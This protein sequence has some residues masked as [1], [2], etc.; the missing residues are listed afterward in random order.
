M[1]IVTL[2]LPD[3]KRQTE[4]RP[5]TCPNCYGTTFQRWGKVTKPVKDQ[6]HR[7]I[8]VY[9]YRCCHCW[10]TF[11]HYP[12]GV[13]RAD[14]TRRLRKLVALMWVLGLSLRYTCT[15]LSAFGV[16]LSHMSVWRNL[17]EQAD[18]QR[19][20]RRWLSTRVI[21]V[22]GVYVRCQGKT[23]PVLVVVDLGRGEPI[24]IGYVDEHD[25]RAVA[26]FLRPIV[27]RLGV[28]VVVSDDLQSYRTVTDQ[29]DV[30]HQV[31]QFHLRRW[32]SGKL[33]QL[34]ETVPKQWRWVVEHTQTI[35]DELPVDGDRQ[36]IELYKQVNIP[37]QGR[38]QEFSPV[39]QLRWLLIRLSENWQRYRVF[40]WQPEVPWTNNGTEQLI[41]R[42]KM[43]ARTVRGYKSTRGML[44]ALLLSGL[45][46]AC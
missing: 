40:D 38:D 26:R 45:G 12:E 9:R 19:Q 39:D 4:I 23:Q 10:R 46:A 15:V 27:Q 7:T 37:R 1:S 35:L 36:L 13:D 2:R 3:V 20:R 11:R 43:R 42:M 14:Q 30:E 28:S 21:G 18:L 16:S 24:E 31:C 33:R 25:P 5:K 34:R 44:A 32:V 6:R 8:S 17:Q 22:D 41:G 29:L